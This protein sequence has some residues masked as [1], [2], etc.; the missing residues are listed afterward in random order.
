LPTLS[1]SY[2]CFCSIRESHYDGRADVWSLGITTI[3]M[4]EGAPPHANLNPLRAIFVIPTKPAPTLADPDNWSPE[5]L[6][7]VRCCC[8]KD[9][10]Q[11]HDSAL[12]SSHPFVKQE[13]IALRAMHQGDPIA[14]NITAPPLSPPSLE[15]HA[16]YVKMSATAD[17]QPGLIGL[18]RVME[19]LQPKLDSIRQKRGHLGTEEAVSLNGGITEDT[20][21][22]L[23]HASAS[24]S[25]VD[26]NALTVAMK[27]SREMDESM[28]GSGHNVGNGGTPYPVGTNYGNGPS[29]AVFATPTPHGATPQQQQQQ[30][31]QAYLS[32]QSSSG[33]GGGGDGSNLDSS[34]SG[35]FTPDSC[36][37]DRRPQLA[38]ENLEPSLLND[39][40][41]QEELKKLARTFETRLEA[42]RVAHE[43]AQEKLVTEARLRNSMPLD[44]NDLM[45]KAAERNVKEKESRKALQEAADTSVLQGFIQGTPGVSGSSPR[46]GSG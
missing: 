2:C 20:E 25:G 32:H 10:A 21:N 39:M 26:S 41:F 19:R 40:V 46:N 37:Y 23:Y 3:E 42:L 43:L 33:G 44:V 7:F 17:R 30:Q 1:L 29:P 22:S 45:E 12:L 35:L 5:M 15:Q 27:P 24:L 28:D 13:V 4:A 11:R 6:D 14:T 36:Q 18:R 16:K 9:P 34:N 8:Q 38:L 31:H